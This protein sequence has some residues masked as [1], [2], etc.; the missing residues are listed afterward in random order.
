MTLEHAPIGGNKPQQNQWVN[1]RATVRYQCAP[2]TAGKVHV[3]KDQEFQS[4]WVQDLSLAGMGIVL[5]RAIPSG[6]LIVVQLKSPTR[7][8]KYELT[9]HVVH[10]TRRPVGDFLLGCEFVHELDDDQLDQLLYDG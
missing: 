10:S 9:A 3:V 5:Q 7:Y 4:G 6:T 2:A 1:H 8:K